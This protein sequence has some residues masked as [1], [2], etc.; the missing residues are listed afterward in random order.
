MRPRRFPPREATPP[1]PPS[2]ASSSRGQAHLGED[3][4]VEHREPGDGAESVGEGCRGIRK[5]V[6]QVGDT[7]AAERP[8]RRPHRHAPRA[9]RKLGHPVV[10]V[11]DGLDGRQ[12]RRVRAERRRHRRLVANDR[13]AAVVRDVEGLVRVGRPRVRVGEPGGRDA[14]ASESPP[15]RGRRRRRRAPM[16]RPRGRPRSRRRSRRTRPSGRRPPAVRRWPGPRP[17]RAPGRGR[18][19]RSGPHRRHPPSRGR[20]GRPS[21]RRAPRR[22]GRRRRRGSGC[23]GRPEAR[24][25][26]RGRCGG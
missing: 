15:P 23:A 9:A 25:R 10:G 4:V 22:C 1:A 16:R 20:R 26:D 24:R 7:A 12:I 3:H 6:D 17:R 19:R 5:P 8:E 14:R 11:G 18:R 21:A 13:E 2:A